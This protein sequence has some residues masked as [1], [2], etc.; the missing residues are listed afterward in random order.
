MNIVFMGTPDFAVPILEQLIK[1]GYNVVGVVTQPDKPKGRKQQLTP[2]PVKV[3]AE[4][5]GIPVFQPTKIR[6]KEQY[7]HVIAL[8]PDLIVTAAFG[9]ILPK[10]LLDA[11]TYGCINVHASL[12]PEL[13]GGAPIHYAILQGKE[14]TGITIMYMVEKLD[15]GDILTQVEVPIDERDTVGTLHDKL[16]QAGARLLSETLPKL[17]RGD[18]M[19]I[20]QDDEQA[21]FAY[22]IK[23]EQERIDWTK[24]GEDIYN[25]IRGMNPWP[26]AYTMYGEERWKI[27]WGEK[28][29]ASSQAK[30]GT[31]VA[32]EQDGIIVATGNE[33]AIKITELQPA[34]KR[35]MSAT[36]F[37]RGTTISIG[38]VLG[39]T[40]E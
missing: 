12:L 1:D 18:I 4:S 21:T 36:D 39:G 37:L 14:K 35:K 24:T 11:P 8:Q 20:K 27:W 10:P 15:A 29:P 31:I 23:P 38:T 3:A 22:N 2:P 7:E 9:Q 5:Y 28:V 16:S 25:H 19:P 32:V 40:N 17:L 13:R 26:V 33:T 30:P 6:E 34:G